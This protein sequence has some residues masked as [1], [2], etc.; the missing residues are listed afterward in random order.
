MQF[1][2][3]EFIERE[4]ELINLMTTKT[5]G[6]KS[7]KKVKQKFDKLKGLM[8]NRFNCGLTYEYLFNLLRIY[9]DDKYNTNTKRLRRFIK[10]IKYIERYARTKQ[11]YRDYFKLVRYRKED[12]TGK[13]Q[14]QQDAE[15]FENIGTPF[16]KENGSRVKT[17]HLF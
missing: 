7:N 9:T 11:A 2:E 3:N 8:W 16:I 1:K 4:Q 10:K 5:R 17:I 12:Y 15:Q 13:E 6:D 14:E